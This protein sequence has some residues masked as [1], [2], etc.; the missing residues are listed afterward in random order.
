MRRWHGDHP[1]LPTLLVAAC[2]LGASAWDKD[3][4]EAIGM[5]AMS[6]LEGPAAVQVKHLMGGR[7]AVDVAAWAHKV[8]KKYPWTLPL[9]NQ[10]QPSWKCEG[11][12]TSVCPD[13]KC[14]VKALKHFYGRLT[15]QNFVTIDWPTG[16]AL[17]D[18]DAV[19]YLINLM[20]DL[21][22]PMHLSVE[23]EDMG[24]N[25]S[26]KFRGKQ[27]SMFELW[28]SGITQAIM[29]DSPSFWWGGWTHVQRTRVEYEKDGEKWKKDGVI[30]F[31]H[32]ADETSKFL[33]ETIHTNPLS[34]RPMWVTGKGEV[35]VDSN[36]FEIWKREMLSR[37]LVAGA[38][39]AIVL[40]AILRH[41][42]GMP[43]LHTGSAVKD[44][45][46]EDDPDRKQA[47]AHGRL[48]DGAHHTH[49]AEEGLKA[50]CINLGIFALTSGVFLQVM[51]MW[52][53]RDAVNQAS[54]A[55][56]TNAEGG[57]KT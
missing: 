42:E 44:L 56:A 43:E 26:V 29:H 57:K 46:G 14:L 32:W 28:D 30:S 17:T 54:R 1:P 7:D 55:K 48:G 11:T 20:G 37:M 52:Q 22:Q 5:V 3:G 2:V 31:D 23:S 4:H 13:N 9:H 47:Q 34:G 41:R 18:A 6:A 49:G 8:N 12:D 25:L 33:C 38:R 16:M 51:K 15:G 50:A 40:N 35:H 36:L 24:R 21:H 39:T 45:E 53:G 10:P 19:K 27:Y